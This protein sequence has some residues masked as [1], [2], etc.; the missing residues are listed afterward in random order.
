MGLDRP[1]LS[2]YAGVMRAFVVLSV[3]SALFHVSACGSSPSSPQAGAGG[4]GGKAS[5]GAGT[6]GD[7]PTNDS[8]RGGS[9]GA[10]VA[11]AGSS[12]AHGKPTAGRGAGGATDLGG[13]A[14]ASGAHPADEAGGAP[15]AGQGGEAGSTPEP[16]RGGRGG[17]GVGGTSGNPDECNCD[18]AHYCDEGVCEIKPECNCA[19]LGVECS[20]L[21]S[22]LGVDLACPIDVQCGSCDDG[23]LCVRNRNPGLPVQS[24]I[25]RGTNT[26]STYSETDPAYSAG[27]GKPPD[28]A[29]LG[30]A[31]CNTAYLFCGPVALPDGTVC[32]SV[33][34]WYCGPGG[35]T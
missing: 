3:A 35:P 8:G 20:T 10:G 34:A 22:A 32:P 18:A 15:T 29:S 25:T 6:G 13:E 24:C 23:Q 16:Q 14:G 1:G 7:A 30:P 5:I 26:C 4:S 11:I 2:A 21:K 19:A 9:G 27:F 31:A 33:N 17:T 28:C 12:G